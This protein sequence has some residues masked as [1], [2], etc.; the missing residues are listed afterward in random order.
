MPPAPPAELRE[1]L[2]TDRAAIDTFN[3]KMSAIFNMAALASCGHCGRSFHEAAFQR[4]QKVCTV[5]RPMNRV[6]HHAMARQ[7]SASQAMHQLASS[8]SPGCITPAAAGP[9][10]PAWPHS[11]AVGKHGMTTEDALAASAQDLRACCICGRT[12]PGEALKRHASVCAKAAIRKCRPADM[13]SRRLGELT[14]TEC[15]TRAGS[16]NS[17]QCASSTTVSKGNEVVDNARWRKQSQELCQAMQASRERRLNNGESLADMPHIASAPD[18]S[19][20][21]CPHCGRRFNDKAAERHIPSCA[22]TVNKPKFLKAG[23]G[24]AGKGA[25]KLCARVPGR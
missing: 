6:R 3:S 13:T 14:T 23:T 10:R 1:P 21:P 2:P 18:L 19:L 24:G 8:G 5:E 4:H 17:K 25:P 15:P 16:G 11:K 22:I 12:F 9:T 7:P 20:I